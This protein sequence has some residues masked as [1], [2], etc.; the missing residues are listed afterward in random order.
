MINSNFIITF[1]YSL[2]ISIALYVA[3]IPG[4][5]FTI[6]KSYK[7]DCTMF[8]KIIVGSAH[9]CLFIIVYGLISMNC[10]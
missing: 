6:P 10:K 5:L 3:F 8:G 1:I 2:I 4:I 9:G 7:D